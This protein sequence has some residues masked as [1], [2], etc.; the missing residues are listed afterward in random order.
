MRRKAVWKWTNL[1]FSSFSKKNGRW[2]TEVKN[3]YIW[4]SYVLK[5]RSN[6]RFKEGNQHP[7][8]LPQH[9]KAS[10]VIFFLVSS[11]I[12]LTS[13][14]REVLK[15]TN[16]LCRVPNKAV[17][18]NR[19]KQWRKRIAPSL[20]KWIQLFRIRSPVVFEIASK[21]FVLSKVECLMFLSFCLCL[22]WLRCTT[23]KPIGF[24][25]LAKFNMN[26]PFPQNWRIWW[27]S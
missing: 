20:H 4:R 21:V 14:L 2:Q 19:I 22:F 25:Q 6:S 9:L 13:S 18:Q 12:L 16:H 15:T 24:Q 23:K 27:P 26:P 1:L 3:I 17:Y 5:G 10:P 8:Y 11:S 7:I